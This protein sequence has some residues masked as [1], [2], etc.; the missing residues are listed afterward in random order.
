MLLES[1]KITEDLQILV[2]FILIL[3][4]I[5]ASGIFLLQVLILVDCDTS[6][7]HLFFDDGQVRNEFFVD[8]EFVGVPQ[9][10]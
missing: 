1:V 4:F 7:R 5:F 8:F 2:K 3:T 9:S 6:G 10:F